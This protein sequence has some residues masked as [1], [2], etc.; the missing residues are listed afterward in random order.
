MISLKELVRRHGSSPILREL[1]K[2]GD[3]ASW[4]SWTAVCMAPDPPP[5]SPNDVPAEMG[6]LAPPE[7]YLS[8]DE[9]DEASSCTSPSPSPLL[10]AAEMTS[11]RLRI[12]R[13]E[14][15]I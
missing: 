11:E 13:K 9:Q 15:P 7:L 10:R 1:Q 6:N 3:Q 2:Q 5:K 12:L 14:S 4:D 8:Y